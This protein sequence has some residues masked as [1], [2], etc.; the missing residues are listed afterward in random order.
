MLKFCQFA[1]CVLVLVVDVQIR[2][3]WRRVAVVKERG[4]GEGAVLKMLG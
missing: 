1:S 3:H 4:L 2:L